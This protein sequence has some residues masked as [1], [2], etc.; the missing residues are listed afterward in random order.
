MTSK[1][2]LTV[3]LPTDATEVS[4][5]A[6]VNAV[7]RSLGKVETVSESGTVKDVQ[8]RVREVKAPA[9]K[10][11]GASKIREWARAAGHEVGKRGRISADLLALYTSQH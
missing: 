8:Y 2:T 5:T 7:R 1:I 4:G 11:T 3:T 9:K 10:D 6:I